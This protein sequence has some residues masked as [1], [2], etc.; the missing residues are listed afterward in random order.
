ML[1][2]VLVLVLKSAALPLV[3]QQSVQQSVVQQLVVL[4]LEA[5]LLEGLRSAQ[6]LPW[7]DLLVQESR[8]RYRPSALVSV[9]A[10]ASVAAL[11]SV[12][13]SAQPSVQP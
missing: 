10:S 1:R 5:P 9:A 8:L 6:S 7:G 2:E 13:V 11:A 3:V 12:P 4:P